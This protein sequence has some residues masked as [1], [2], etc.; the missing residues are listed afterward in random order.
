MPR[1][2]L[3]RQLGQFKRPVVGR[4][5]CPFDKQEIAIGCYPQVI[6]RVVGRDDHIGKMVTSKC[7]SRHSNFLLAKVLDGG[8]LGTD[9]RR[10]RRAAVVQRGQRAVVE[11]ALTRAL[12]AIKSSNQ[13]RIGVERMGAKATNTAINIQLPLNTALI[14]A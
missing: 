3:S 10:P 6:F 14:T 12:G 13:P 8:S 4:V 2:L 5:D 11:G 9:Q 7:A 1:D